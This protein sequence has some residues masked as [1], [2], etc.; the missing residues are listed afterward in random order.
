MSDRYL[1]KSILTDLA[2][3]LNSPEKRIQFWFQN[4][5]MKTKKTKNQAASV[6]QATKETPNGD[7]EEEVKTRCSTS[8]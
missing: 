8:E 4:R 6:N 1:T 3:R 2:E 7:E 5:R